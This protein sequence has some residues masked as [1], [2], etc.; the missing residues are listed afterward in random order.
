MVSRLASLDGAGFFS[1]VDGGDSDGSLKI[2][3]ERSGGHGALYTGENSIAAATQ[4]LVALWEKPQLVHTD[5][6]GITVGIETLHLGKVHNSTADAL[7]TLLGDDL[8]GDELLEC[9]RVDT[10]VHSGVPVCRQGVVCTGGVVSTR[11]WGV[12]AHEDGPCVVN[13]RHPGLGVLDLQDQV[14]W[15]IS[16]GHL[17]SVVHRLDLDRRRVRNTLSHNVD[18]RQLQ[19]LSVDSLVDAVDLCV[20]HVDGKENHL[21]VDTVFGL[22]EQVGGDKV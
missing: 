11:L 6:D 16:V 15:G 3:N 10:A 2:D 13:L 19:G 21:R 8:G 18:S 4:G 5:S 9:R 1:I 17:E 12:C 14:F 20:G 22:R 7:E